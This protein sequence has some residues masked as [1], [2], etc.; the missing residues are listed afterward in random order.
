MAQ[1]RNGRE[2][3]AFSSPPEGQTEML[4]SLEGRGVGYFKAQSERDYRK[5]CKGSRDYIQQKRREPNGL[6]SI[7]IHLSDFI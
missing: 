6:S 4:P 5:P 2:L 1:R 7:K 3:R